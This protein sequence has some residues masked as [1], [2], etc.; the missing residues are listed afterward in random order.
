[1][2]E[3]GGI[4]SIGTTFEICDGLWLTDSSYPNLSLV[5]HQGNSTHDH[6]SFPGPS[7]WHFRKD[8][9]SFRI[10]AA[11]L[12]VENPLLI[13]FSKA[14][15]DL[16]NSQMLEFHDIFVYSS[17]IWCTQHIKETRG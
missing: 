16:D 7:F 6:P 14:G 9:E 3:K 10:F 17:P 13:N 4:P 5:K 11:E 1:M 2:F 8:R 12:L 15:H